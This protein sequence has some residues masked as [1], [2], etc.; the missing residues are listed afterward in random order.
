M[1]TMN[2]CSQQQNTRTRSSHRWRHASISYVPRLFVLELVARLLALMLLARVLRHTSPT[3]IMNL[4]Q[5]KVSLR[6]RQQHSRRRHR[7][8]SYAYAS[9]VST[10]E[11]W[12]I[13]GY[14]RSNQKS[15]LWKDSTPP[16]PSLIPH[17]AKSYSV[18]TSPCHLRPFR[19]TI[20]PAHPRCQNPFARSAS[21]SA[22]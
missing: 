1:S 5:L 15:H 7:S 18:T 16:T 17:K 22:S 10:G 3:Q 12:L 8:M 14:C 2:S 9:S 13:S 20:Y 4:V 19:Q 21:T 6:A 11:G